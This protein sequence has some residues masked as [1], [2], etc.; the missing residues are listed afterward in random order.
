MLPSVFPHWVAH[1]D[2]VEARRAELEEIRVV[3]MVM[4]LE[5]SEGRILKD[6]DVVLL[7]LPAVSD[8]VVP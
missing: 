7:L 6:R 2:E 4:L 1:G 5:T 3:M 8:C